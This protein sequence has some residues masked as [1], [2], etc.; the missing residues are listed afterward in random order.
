MLIISEEQ[1]EKQKKL[2][3]QATVIK[4]MV[5][6]L[7]LHRKKRKIM[8]PAYTHTHAHKY[9]QILWCHFQLII[10]PRV[11]REVMKMPPTSMNLSVSFESNSIHVMKLL[12]NTDW[13]VLGNRY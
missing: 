2:T 8:C 6:T 5:N 10:H 3:D 7:M 9:F 11:V 13:L 4:T 1:L 12:K